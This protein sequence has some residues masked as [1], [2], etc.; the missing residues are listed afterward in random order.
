MRWHCNVSTW[1]G[2]ATFPRILFPAHIQSGWSISDILVGNT[3]AKIKAAPILQL[4]HIFTYLMI[5]LNGVIQWLGL[6]LPYLPLHFLLAFYTSGSDAC[7]NLNDKRTQLL[8]DTHI[9]KVRGNKPD[10][11]RFLVCS[12][13]LHLV[14]WT[15]AYRCFPPLYI[16][17][18]FLMACLTPESDTKTRALQRAKL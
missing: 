14:L 15:P 7:V 5:H 10:L 8:H 4:T 12:C 16:H 11:I 6:P 17:P 9:I 1:L 3:E 2:G 18:L 13:G